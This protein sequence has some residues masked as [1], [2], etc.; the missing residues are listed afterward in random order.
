M[1]AMIN[2]REGVKVARA[3][4]G[5]IEVVRQP[6]E[7]VM[8]STSSL[9]VAMDVELAGGLSNTCGAD[10]ER[11][12]G[13]VRTRRGS[14]RAFVVER[15][16]GGGSPPP[17]SPPFHRHDSLSFWPTMIPRA[18]LDRLHNFWSLVGEPNS[19]GILDPDCPRM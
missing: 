18:K 13:H 14:E 16:R 7:R 8:K 6:I 15:E 11:G 10:A 5:R 2:G 3:S 19:N 17:I 1:S 12:F 4:K 9:I